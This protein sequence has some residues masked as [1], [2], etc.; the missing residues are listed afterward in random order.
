MA[1]NTVDPSAI[2]IALSRMQTTM[3][4]LLDECTALGREVELVYNQE[5]SNAANLVAIDGKVTNV[6]TIVTGTQASVDSI[7]TTDYTTSIENIAATQQQ[8][9]TQLNN[10]ENAILAIPDSDVFKSMSDQLES[11]HAAVGYPPPGQDIWSRITTITNTTVG[12]E[13]PKVRVYGSINGDLTCPVNVN[14]YDCLSND[15][16]ANTQVDTATNTFQFYVIPGRFVV[17]FSG[18][19]INTTSITVDVPNVTSYEIV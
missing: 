4:N 15:I 17:E 12:S 5:M 10:I 8:I 6:E 11:I 2:A 1:G 14:V 7:P 16:A 19:T 18:S 13:T 9:I 3:S